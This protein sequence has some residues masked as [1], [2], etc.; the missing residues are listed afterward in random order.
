MMHK[1]V[2]TNDMLISLL[3]FIG[4]SYAWEVENWSTIFFYIVR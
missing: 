2:S 1:K 3:V 4:A